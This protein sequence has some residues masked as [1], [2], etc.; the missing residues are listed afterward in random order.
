MLNTSKKVMLLCTAYAMT[1]H[2]LLF[3]ANAP[4]QKAFGNVYHSAALQAH[5]LPAAGIHTAK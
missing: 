4:L 5:V 1:L 2:I 3:N